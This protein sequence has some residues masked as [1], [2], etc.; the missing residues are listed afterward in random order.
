[1]TD[2]TKPPKLESANVLT[3]R[4][5]RQ[6]ADAHRAM[7]N[8]LR[9]AELAGD[10]AAVGEVRSALAQTA[11]ELEGLAEKHAPREE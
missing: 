1:M 5:L 10:W 8:R 6:D 3:A 9:R 7:A 11:L 2:E 4:V